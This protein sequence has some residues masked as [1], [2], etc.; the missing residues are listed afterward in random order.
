MF[1][2]DRGTPLRVYPC[3]AEFSHL[4][5]QLGQLPGTG[6]RNRLVRHSVDPF[7]QAFAKKAANGHQQQTDR[8][9]GSDE[10]AAAIG[11]SLADPVG[12]DWIKHKGGIL[13]ESQRGGCVDPVAVPARYSQSTEYLR[14]VAASLAGEH[15][16]AAS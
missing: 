5:S 4:P 1:D 6:T 9:V 8:A 7:D 3:G 15:G 2:F 12:I 13:A 14:R 16:F 11:E 10:V